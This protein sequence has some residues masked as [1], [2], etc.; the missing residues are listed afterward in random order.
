MSLTSALTNV[1]IWAVLVAAVVHLVLGLVWFQK[2]LFGNA[3]V[4]LTGKTL[5]PAKQWLP[6]GVIGH[7]LMAY[8]LAVIINLAGAVTMGAGA[9]IGLLALV[10]FVIPLECGELVWEKIPFKLWLIRVGNQ[11]VGLAVTG[12][13]L[14]VWR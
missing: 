2:P 7:L 1:N 13:I 10:G 12:A 11:L 5:D 8:V 3:W 4:A 14:A 6:A 9:L